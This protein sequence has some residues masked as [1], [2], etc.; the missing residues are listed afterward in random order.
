MAL[1]RK[2]LKKVILQKAGAT[3]LQRAHMLKKK[4]KPAKG[5]LAAPLA[6]AF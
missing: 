6:Q 2:M 5:L 3:L 1:Q 4:G